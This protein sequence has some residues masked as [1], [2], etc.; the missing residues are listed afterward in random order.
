MGISKWNNYDSQIIEHL[1][2]GLPYNSIA[3]ALL[4]SEYGGHLNPEVKALGEYIRR[5]E[6]RL[7]DQHEG[8]YKATDSI[9]VPNTSVKHMWLKD[10]E[11]SIFVKNP[12]FVDE[13]ETEKQNL[14]QNIENEQ[15]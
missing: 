8:I 12:N 6:K 7:L 11:K 15:T 5:H 9:D 13:S 10:K 14:L 1:N 3:K 4:N 2:K